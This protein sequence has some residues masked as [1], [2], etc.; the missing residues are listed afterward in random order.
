MKK[1]IN[2]AEGIAEER[3]RE[4]PRTSRP[5]RIMIH[6]YRDNR[7]FVAIFYKHFETVEGATTELHDLEKHQSWAGC[8]FEVIRLT[9]VTGFNELEEI[10]EVR[11]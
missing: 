1:K 5:Y 7:P 11:S 6:E 2:F 9:G 4:N 10:K 3:L 8:E